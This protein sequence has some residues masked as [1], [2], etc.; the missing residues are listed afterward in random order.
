MLIILIP[1]SLRAENSND[2]LTLMATAKYTGACGLMNSMIVFQS[3]TKMNGGDD[4]V[5]R[6]LQ[7]EAARLGMTVEERFKLCDQ[8]IS[9]YDTW[10]KLMKSEKNVE[11]K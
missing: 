6:F 4:F 1:S 10:F 5:E 11:I 9:N 2:A 7:T 8:A 3:Q